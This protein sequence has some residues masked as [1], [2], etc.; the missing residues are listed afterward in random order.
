MSKPRQE[1]IIDSLVEQTRSLLEDHWGEAERVFA[2]DKIKIGVALLVDWEG[3]D[4]NCK[5]T[6][7]FGAR[8]KDSSEALVHD[9]PELPLTPAEQKQGRRRG[10]SA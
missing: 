5:A 1:K 2:E 10:D 4:A 8:V 9:Q 7:S 6:I 3:T